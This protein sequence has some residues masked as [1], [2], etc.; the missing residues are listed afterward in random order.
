M[1]LWSRRRHCLREG[2][3]EIICP[4]LA[5]VERLSLRRLLVQGDYLLQSLHLNHRRPLLRDLPEDLRPFFRVARQ[6]LRCDAFKSLFLAVRSAR[7]TLARRSS[8]RIF[9]Q[10][11]KRGAGRA[12]AKRRLGL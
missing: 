8:P 3:K 11:L 2:E 10:Y 9:E 12:V 7:F 1:P 5:W 4:L 6:R